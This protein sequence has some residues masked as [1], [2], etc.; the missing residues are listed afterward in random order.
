MAVFFNK[1]V[2]FLKQLI[3]F[4]LYKNAVPFYVTSDH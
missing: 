3:T 2:D 4:A 1:I